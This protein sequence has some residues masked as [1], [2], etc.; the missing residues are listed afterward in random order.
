[1]SSDKFNQY[2]ASASGA[3]LILQKSAE[4]TGAHI[5]KMVVLHNEKVREL[6]IRIEELEARECRLL[7]EEEFARISL[8]FPCYKAYKVEVQRKFAEVNG[9]KLK[10]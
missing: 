4:Q 9:L 5:L 7:T 1:M 3:V 2:V 8:N 10:P 6:E